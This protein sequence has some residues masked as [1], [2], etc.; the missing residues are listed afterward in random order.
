MQSLDSLYDVIIVGGGIAG[1]STAWHLQ[2]Q[3]CQ[4]YALLEAS[5]RWGGHIRTEHVPAADGQ[6]FVVE[7]GPDSFLT[8]KP[9]ALELARTLG[10]GDDL[11]GTHPHLKQVYVLQR[12][13]PVPMPEGV[14]SIVPTRFKPF[15][16]SPLISPLGKLRMGLELFIPPRRDPADETL[17][18]FVRRRLG[19]EALDKI[20]E[21]L[22]SGIYNSE[23]ERQ[24]LLATFPR[25]RALESRYGSLT[26]GMLAARQPAN[27]RAD[28]APSMFMTPR[29]GTGELVR[30]LVAR[31]RGDLCLQAP[32]QHV[33]L[34]GDGAYELRL[35]GGAVLRA[36]AL[37][38]AVPAFVAAALLAPLAPGAAGS[39][40]Q[41]RYVSTG[42]ISLAWRLAD[43]RRP[44]LGYGV[45]VPRSECRPVNALTWS[46]LKFAGRAPEGY[47]LFRLFFGGSRSPA[48][49]SLDD[50]A[51]LDTVRRE[52]RPLLGIEAPPLFHRIY[53]MQQSNPQYDV[54]HLERMA[55]VEA[56]LPARV[57][58]TGSGYRGVGIPDCVKQGA[59]TA[60]R[61]VAAL[62][63]W[64]P[65][66]ECPGAAHA[67]R[68]PAEP[69][70]QES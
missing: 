20:A 35:T 52:L 24:S 7:A 62:K 26:R 15:V 4:H 47:A 69:F 2:Q 51:L 23:A 40:R 14:M 21:P 65:A 70:S 45:V 56:A 68:L 10:L 46:S 42:T 28:S 13:R 27:G 25:F 8:Q 17:A 58:L 64:S 50:D 67:P 53:R 41:V 30:A 11:L 6:S 12:G 18:A 3:G 5:E 48:S 38:L 36:R 55:E 33:A 54:G 1:L 66:T 31:L 60:A 61:V 34:A 49:M 29:Q 22:L 19:G 39:L 57:Y 37:V 63:S 59:D 16:L 32:V 9:W 44:L 43:V